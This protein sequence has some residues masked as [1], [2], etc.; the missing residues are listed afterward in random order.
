M[1]IRTVIGA[2][3]AGAADFAARLFETGKRGISVLSSL[4]RQF[5]DL[6]AGTA[7]ALYAR[8][9]ADA[10]ALSAFSAGA[11]SNYLPMSA[12]RQSTLP[13]LGDRYLYAVQL[14]FTDALTGAVTWKTVE[15]PSPVRLTSQQVYDEANAAWSTTLGDPRNY[16]LNQVSS[17][18]LASGQRVARAYRAV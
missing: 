3:R 4:R 17:L 1:A 18:L 6:A 7:S 15:V 16:S 11:S 14:Q 13:Q 5:P 10:Q 8:V 2:L 9:R 12:H